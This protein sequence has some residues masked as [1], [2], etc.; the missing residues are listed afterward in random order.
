MAYKLKEK[1]S[2][3]KNYGGKRST[4]K[5]QWIVIHYTANDGDSDEANGKYFAN[6]VVK[7]S[8]HYFV[9]SDSVT[10]SVKDNYVAWSVGGNK[11]NNDGGKYYGKVTNTNSLSIELC[12]DIKN[13]KV[14][15]SE[16]TIQNAILLTKSLMK[17]YG[18]KAEN[19]IR[20]YDVNG[21][22]CP[23]YWVDDAKWK[24]EF[25][26]KL[27]EF[28]SYLVKINTSSLN[29]RAGAGT[30]YNIT[31]TVKKGEIYTIVDEKNGWGR[32]KSGAGWI[33][34]SYTKK[35]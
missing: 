9:D 2:N 17:K 8:A 29:V 3:T 16:A 6:N 12:D 4:D 32:L 11:Y 25:H 15:P 24:K 27:K 21:K 13:G 1:L 22:P 7:S 10:Q 31:A 30:G 23:K 28:D 19:V 20:H 5:I 14:Y 26:D 18:I 34:L 33:K 35:L